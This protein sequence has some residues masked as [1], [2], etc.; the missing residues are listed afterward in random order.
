MVKESKYDSVNM[1]ILLSLFSKYFTRCIL[2]GE[3]YL[4][5]Y[6]IIEDKLL[7]PIK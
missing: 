4:I 1:T 2:G 3:K 7:M 6:H 5:S